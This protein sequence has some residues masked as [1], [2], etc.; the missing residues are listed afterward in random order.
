M[1]DDSDSADRGLGD[2]LLFAIAFAGF[3]GAAGGVILSSPCL[4]LTGVVFT[5]LALWGFLW[6]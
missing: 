2:Y 5:L 6:Q 3:T 1:H 4:A